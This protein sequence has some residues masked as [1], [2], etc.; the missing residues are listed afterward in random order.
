M[1]KQ[2][3]YLLTCLGLLATGYT[4]KAMNNEKVLPAPRALRPQAVDESWELRATSPSPSH[5]PK[6]T[7]P[8]SAGSASGAITQ[9]SSNKPP[10]P[11]R[12]HKRSGAVDH[13]RHATHHHAHTSP[14]INL[15]VNNVF[16]RPIVAN[17]TYTSETN[18]AG[19]PPL[20]P[21]HQKIIINPGLLNLHIKQSLHRG[22]G[23]FKQTLTLSAI[24]FVDHNNKP[25]RELDATALANQEL[26]SNLSFGVSEAKPPLPHHHHATKGS[27]VVTGSE[28]SDISDELSE[29]GYEAE[30]F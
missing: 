9:P 7:E 17:L 21:I 29:G 24:T 22:K 6:I 30:Q 26:L 2:L 18:S 25:L 8:A 14:R 23:K 16:S 3:W 13:G 20:S 5:I 27:H 19:L 15:N 11:H 12:G 10:L 4:I 1:R 28:E